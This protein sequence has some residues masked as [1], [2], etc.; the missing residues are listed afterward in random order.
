LRGGPA[1]YVRPGPLSNE[2]CRYDD[3]PF[4]DPAESH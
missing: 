1:L 2:L 4:G 3:S